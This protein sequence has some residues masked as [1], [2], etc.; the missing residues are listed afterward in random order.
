MSA[1]LPDLR[2]KSLE[3]YPELTSELEAVFELISLRPP[4]EARALEL[5]FARYM[6]EGANNSYSADTSGFIDFLSKRKLLSPSDMIIDLGAGPGDLIGTLMYRCPLKKFIGIDLSPG[7]VSRFNDQR[8]Q[9]SD[10]FMRLGVIDSPLDMTGLTVDANVISV[11]TLDRLSQPK[12]LIDNMSK[13]TG[14]K[15]LGTLLPVVGEDDN[16][17][18]QGEEKRVYTPPENR[19]VPGRS[20]EEDRE[21]LLRELSR[22]WKSEI[23]YS[24]V[25]YSV[26]SSGDRQRYELG[27]F[28]TPVS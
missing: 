24:E 7:F 16:P 5:A 10:V 1:E 3:D 11:L 25:P 18:L 13:F 19:I 6:E 8:K 15:I 14:S 23:S 2:I 27:V 17:S 9:N 26:G 12:V 22:S 20:S 21:V 4:E 28:Y